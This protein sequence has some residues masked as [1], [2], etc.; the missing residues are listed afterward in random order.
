MPQS[1]APLALET[2]GKQENRRQTFSAR[3][4]RASLTAFA[5]RKLR[6]GRVDLGKRFIQTRFRLTATVAL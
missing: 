3:H 6:I 2:A 1:T 4:T 5:R